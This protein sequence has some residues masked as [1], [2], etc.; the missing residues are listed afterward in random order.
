MSI[1]TILTSIP[2]IIP[3][4]LDFRK[5]FSL[6]VLKR[7]LDD[8]IFKL[9]PRY[10][11]ELHVN[12]PIEENFKMLAKDE[13][14]LSCMFPYFKGFSEKSNG[15]GLVG[16]SQYDNLVD[17]FKQSV[18]FI[19]NFYFSFEKNRRKPVDLDSLKNEIEKANKML[20]NICMCGLNLKKQ[21]VP[22]EIKNQ[23]QYNEVKINDAGNELRKLQ[24]FFNESG[25]FIQNQIMLIVGKAGSG[26]SH[27]LAD[28]ATKRLQCKKWTCL[29]L[30][31]TFERGSLWKQFLEKMSVKWDEIIFLRC[32]NLYGWLKRCR[33]LIFIDALNEC[34]VPN[35]WAQ[36]LEMFL[37][38]IRK[39]PNVGVVLSVRSEY[40]DYVISE[41]VQSLL[42]LVTH[43]GF[44]TASFEAVKHFFEYY[45][46]NLPNTPMLNPEFS[47]PLFLK[48]FCELLKK[49]G[50][51]EIPSGFNSLLDIF[52]NYIEDVNERISR[53]YN[54]DPSLYL[55]RTSIENIALEMLKQKKELISSECAL[56]SLDESFCSSG[57]R[58][59]DIFSELVSEGILIKS[60]DKEKKVSILFAY[61]RYYD[62]LVAKALLGT[63]HNPENIKLMF[64]DGGSLH[65]YVTSEFGFFNYVGLL[66]AWAILLPDNYDLELFE[67]IA[68]EDIIATQEPFIEGLLWRKKI[69][70]RKIHNYIITYILPEK[71]Y[72]NKWL[73]TLLLLCSKPECA[74]NSD[75]LHEYL[76]PLSMGN[77]DAE[78]SI[79]ISTQD[80][81]DINNV[82]R[83]IDWTW[84][85]DDLE[86]LSDESTRLLGQMLIW[87]L[88]SMNREVRDESSTALVNLLKN[89]IDVLI[90]LLDKFK[91][92]ND[93]YVLQRMYAV[94]FGCVTNNFDKESIKRLCECVYKNIFES[95]Y[96]VPDILLRDYAMNTIEYG[97]HLGINFAFDVKKIYPPYKSVMPS[98]LP[99]NNIVDANLVPYLGRAAASPEYAVNKIIRSMVTEYGRGTANYGYFG[100]YV[101]DR[102]FKYWN[103]DT[104]LLSN[105][106]VMWILKQS[107][108]DYNI[109]G[110]FDMN[111]SGDGSFMHHCERIGKKYQWIIFYD[112]LA[113]VSDN[114]QMKKGSY[115]GSF[116]PFVRDF[117]PT[118]IKKSIYSADESFY[119]SI[120]KKFHWNQKNRKWITKKNNFPSIEKFL[121]EKDADNVEWMIL[122]KSIHL[123]QPD[124]LDGMFKPKKDFFCS[125]NSYIMTDNDFNS[126]KSW[127][128]RQNFY[129]RSLPESHQCYKAYSREYCWSKAYEAEYGNDYDW[130]TISDSKEN[131]VAVVALTN[132]C[133]YW[134]NEYDHSK[135]S[136]FSFIR[137]SKELCKL[138]GLHQGIKDGEF[139]D[140]SGLVVC[141]NPSVNEK[142]PS[143]LMV[144]KK[145]FLNAL[146]NNGLKIAW[147]IL[148]EKRI[149]SLKNEDDYTWMTLSGI[150]YMRCGKPTVKM[151]HFMNR[152]KS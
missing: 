37:N 49:R 45:E 19:A 31:N 101:W 84:H 44:N 47:N 98:N 38:D 111:V 87:F 14:S 119:S 9:G 3:I 118:T 15:V 129:G 46:I 92:V 34:D 6:D 97:L 65:E 145:E 74:L 61:E 63:E 113:R 126:F 71:Y 139:V 89:K 86:L 125:V 57:I 150:G 142:H 59:V 124:R 40:K 94:A 62:L 36:N 17:N 121:V 144:R 91:D 146:K 127:A 64:K 41:R 68:D 112:L 66:N 55:I 108:Y 24:K 5:I 69:D 67:I 70:I 116:E 39:Y 10:T 28:I 148:G 104:N 25:R 140:E 81:S 110:E 136:L 56:K 143:C 106:A 16:N 27:L 141:K 95:A 115:K 128:K 102:A 77:R 83:I 43:K 137:P 58:A 48:L 85:N 122:N 82:K 11:P 22:K 18:D 32:L 130:D 90:C 35:F 73:D 2:K 96:V 117:D 50:L 80:D 133:Y 138:M 76:F 147:T 72:K 135:R 79:F 131:G 42:C 134:E 152:V 20:V 114:Y 100:R 53:K 109:H 78:W 8:S 7:K 120:M 51:H 93:P 151:N 52:K 29:F 13:D 149:D 33:C 132:Y 21:T 12:L 30:G 105:Y 1:L 75:Y 60:Y 23:I 103:V 26:K 123:K 107:G 99:S 54:I 88:T 4:I